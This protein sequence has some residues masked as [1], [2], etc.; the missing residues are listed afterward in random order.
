MEI[1]KAIILAVFLLSLTFVFTTLIAKTSIGVVKSLIVTLIVAKVWIGVFYLMGIDRPLF[2]IKTKIGNT[3]VTA[4]ML[5]FLT[6]LATNL[7][8]ITRV[9]KL[10]K[11]LG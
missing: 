1:A 5:L 2:V 8:F 11:I 4:M 9:E 10:E 6:T 3:T 7:Y